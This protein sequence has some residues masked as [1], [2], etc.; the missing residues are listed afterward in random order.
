M[1]A[2]DRRA[3]ASVGVSLGLMCFALRRVLQLPVDMLLPP[4]YPNRTDGGGGDRTRVGTTVLSAPQFY[5]ALGGRSFAAVRIHP[6]G[7]LHEDDAVWKQAKTSN[8]F[9]RFFR[10][11]RLTEAVVFSGLAFFFLR[12]GVGLFFFCF[13]RRQGDHSVRRVRTLRRDCF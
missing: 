12:N 3:R 2:I 8:T 13:S 10:C 6:I 7:V 9:G 4:A 1:L 11:S 5:L